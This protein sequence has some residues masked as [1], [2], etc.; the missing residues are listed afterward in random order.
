MKSVALYPR[1]YTIPYVWVTYSHCAVCTAIKAL[2][3]I[4]CV[5][6]QHF[7]LTNRSTCHLCYIVYIGHYKQGTVCIAIYIGHCIQGIINKLPCIRHHTQGT[8]HKSTFHRS[9]FPPCVCVC[10]C[11]RP[12]GRATALVFC[13]LS[14]FSVQRGDGGTRHRP[15]AT[16]HRS[17]TGAVRR[18]SAGMVVPANRI[19]RA[20]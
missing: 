3:Y 5:W 1:P 9:T 16:R 10:V 2:P 17:G 14:R 20:L 11:F 12:S 6:N 13:F 7:L 8:V 15:N 19:N 4:P 18:A